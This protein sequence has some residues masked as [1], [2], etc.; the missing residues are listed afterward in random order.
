MLNTRART[1]LVGAA[2]F[3]AAMLG[4]AQSARAAIYG[5]SWDPA[6][7]AAFSGLG[8]KGSA[9]FFIPD[10][11]LA[12]AGW[13]DNTA[14]TCA[15]GGMK[16]LSA[17]VVL[18]DLNSLAA[19]ETLQFDP[20]VQVY[21]MFVNA[22]Q[23]EGVSSNFLGPVHATSSFAGNGTNYFDLKFLPSTTQ[24]V[25]LY[26]TVG[27]IDPICV[28]TGTPAGCGFSASSPT[29]ILTLV[30]EPATYALVLAGLGAIGLTMR[31]RRQ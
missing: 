1:A 4:G 18:Y 22:G 6:Y 11:C 15:N 24:M 5:G 29:M 27:N 31:R 20:N 12:D 10:A 19:P 2:V 14:S 30:P 17:T 26:H 7:G 23:L 16:V 13:I 3:V 8:W 21:Q 9:T 28:Y 25:Q